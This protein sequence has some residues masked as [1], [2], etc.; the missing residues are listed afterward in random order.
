MKTLPLVPLFLALLCGSTHAAELKSGVF[1]PPRPAPDFSLPSSRGDLFTLS[2]AR[3]KLVV[4]GFGFS[5]C[6]EVC[7]ATLSNL[8][9]AHRNLGEL[10]DE[11][12]VVYVSVDPER[13]TVER[14]HLYMSHFNASFIGTTGEE[15]QLAE[16]RKSYGI[17]TNREDMEDGNYQVHHS[18]FLYLIDR[19]GLL[20]ALVPFGKTPQDIAH[21]IRMLLQD[22]EG[23]K[24]S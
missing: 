11:V 15:A 19:E 20:R 23:S 10:A 8:A 2:Q 6:L 7:P 24:S 18:S 3:G 14:L 12:L 1:D 4:L 17:T 22:G 21:D 13:D 5:Q 16:V 9:Q